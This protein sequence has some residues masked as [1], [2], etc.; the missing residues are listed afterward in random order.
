MLRRDAPFGLR[1]RLSLMPWLA[2]FLLAS[3]PARADAGEAL[4]RELST[5]STGLMAELAADSV[6]AGFAQDG[7]MTIYTAADAER[8]AAAD[9]ASPTGRALGAELLS[10]A[11]ARRLEPALS[12]K[13]RAAVLVPAEARCDPVRFT[14]AL[15]E[16]V[17]A[18]GAVVRTGVVVVGVRSERAGVTLETTH[19]ERRAAHLV[20]AAGV[21]S[22]ALA[23]AV[24]V[25]LPLQ[26]GKGYAVEYELPAAGMR[27]PLY[28]HDERCVANPMDDRLRVT[29]GLLL[30]GLDDRFEPRRAR[31][32]ARAAEAA[33][34]VGAAPRLTWRGL[35]PC[36]PDGLPVVG[37][38]R[39]APRVVFA[40]GHGM[41]GVTLAPL[42]GR[43]VA[44]VVAGRP[45][46]PAL[47]R[48]S[49]ERFGVLAPRP[50]E[51]R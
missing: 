3:T 38:H 21:W 50:Q 51:P 4:Q 1:P 25:T 26:G 40:T 22:G 9:V 32:V 16:R 37:P 28:L 23:R 30:D 47:E 39:R 20:V 6:D 11:A 33:L 45:A 2:R 36:T 35:R 14:R 17:V 19:G 13:V 44:G 12:D 34:D 18:H 43:M 10:G 31:A 48:L 42:T 29:G 27:R 7:S 24:G 46:H 5:E 8:R 49:P 15:A 41:L